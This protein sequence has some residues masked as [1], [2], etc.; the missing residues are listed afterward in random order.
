MKNTDKRLSKFLSYVLRHNPGSIGIELDSKGWVE[1]DTLLVHA[2]RNGTRITRNDLIRI[3]FE[4]DKQRFAVSED[5]QRI[6]ANQGHSVK[7]DLDLNSVP[8]PEM[9]YHGTVERF[10]ESIRVHGLLKGERHHVHLS[11]DE[12]TAS[13]VGARRGKP[14]LLRIASRELGQHGHLFYL[15]KNGVWLTDHVPPQYIV[16]PEERAD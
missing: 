10:L 6:R 16:F 5:S 1:I 8:A 3:V 13:A 14:V 7:V 2:N 15:T 11:A 12:Q 4:S 9:L